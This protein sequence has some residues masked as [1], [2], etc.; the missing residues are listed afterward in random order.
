MSYT[1]MNM[2]TDCH[3]TKLDLLP[4]LV[5]VVIFQCSGLLAVVTQGIILMIDPKHT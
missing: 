1:V 3:L 4:V 2:L 5:V